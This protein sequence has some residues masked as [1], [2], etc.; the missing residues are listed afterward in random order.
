MNDVIHLPLLSAPDLVVLPGMVVPVELDGHSR[1]VIDAAQAGSDGTL[2]LAPRLADRY[3]THGVVATIEQV[4][5]L[6]GGA[7]AAVLRAGARA[8]IGS[9]VQG[10]GAALWVEAEI[11]EEGPLDDHVRELAEEYRKVVIA[12]LQRRNAWQVIDSVQR[13][14]DPSQ[15]ADMAGYASYVS[16]EQKRELLETPDVEGRLTRVLAWARDH[17]AELEVTEK[18]SDDVREGMDKRQREFLLREQL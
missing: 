17:F 18:I 6:P 8:R 1:P 3:P 9:G 13:V 12:I 16:D 4:G 5:R 7:P 10:T 11:V 14:T 2:L 15:L